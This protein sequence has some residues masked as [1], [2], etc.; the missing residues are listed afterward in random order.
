MYKTTRKNDKFNWGKDQEEALENVTEILQNLLVL[1]MPRRKGLLHLYT[2]T[3]KFSTCS[4]LWQ[5][6]DGKEC[7]LAFH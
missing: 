7:L 3:S 1:H 6:I 4:I 2:D 5:V